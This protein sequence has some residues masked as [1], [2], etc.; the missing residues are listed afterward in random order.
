M[1]EGIAAAIRRLEPAAQIVP[2]LDGVDRFILDDLLEDVGGGV[3]VDRSQHEKTPVEPGRKQM[4]EIVVD[5]LQLGMGGDQRQ[6]H[7][8]HAHQQRRASGRQ[9]EASD[10]LLPARFRRRVESFELAAI[11]TVLALIGTNRKLDRTA[12]R[13]KPVRSEE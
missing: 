5:W 2:T 6:Q 13:A 12:L 8:A 9:V 7:L 1:K 3:P 4:D 11:R 10:Q